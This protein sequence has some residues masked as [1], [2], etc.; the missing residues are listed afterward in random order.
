MVLAEMVLSIWDQGH[1]IVWGA[2]VSL[3]LLVHDLLCS[4]L[5]DGLSLSLHLA[6]RRFSPVSVLCAFY[7]F[8]YFLFSFYHNKMHPVP[9]YKAIK[10]KINKTRQ[11]RT[12]FF[13]T[14]KTTATKK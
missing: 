11:H 6:V 7:I 5:S 1:S 2:V 13:L 12:N 3:S 10:N 14:N 9:N 8:F 4:L